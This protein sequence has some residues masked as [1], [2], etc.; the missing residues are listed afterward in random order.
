MEINF[1]SFDNYKNKIYSVTH[2]RLLCFEIFKFIFLYIIM[3]IFSKLSNYFPFSFFGEIN[4][5][6][7]IIIKIF[8]FSLLIDLSYY[9]LFKT[10][11]GIYSYFEIIIKLIIYP[12]IMKIF[13]LLL[14]FYSIYTINKNIELLM[15]KLNLNYINNIYNLESIN[16]ND[17]N[18]EEERNIE[19][20]AYLK[21]SLYVKFYK[22]YSFCASFFLLFYF[23]I[24]KQKFNLWP[25]LELGHI[26]N[27][28]KQI[29]S[30]I[31]NLKIII[32]PIYCIIYITLI[33]FYHTMKVIHLSFYYLTHFILNYILLFLST[34]S[35]INFICPKINYQSYETVTKGQVIRKQINLLKENSFYIIHHLKHLCDFY[36]FPH[37]IKLNTKL[38]SFEDLEIIKKKI[39]FYFDI[40]NKKY[41]LFLDKKKKVITSYIY[42][43]PFYN[44][45]IIIGKISNLIDF[46][47]NQIFENETNVQI[48]KLLIE[49]IGNLILFILDAKIIKSN[50]E[51]LLIYKEYIEILNE[52]LIELDKILSSVF[53]DKKLSEELN[54]DIYK[55]RKII[56]NYFCLIKI[57]QNKMNYII[58]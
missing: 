4:F 42:M 6:S 47:A 22:V 37:D 43:G 17:I 24:I 13:L 3:L 33:Y 35:I 46:S 52:K 38:L 36:I 49:L 18:D 14:S 12:N 23:I 58:E 57:K 56:N 48:I 50:E 45:K 5:V 21:N 40:L 44:L 15:P 26:D 8:F 41:S 16:L 1:F 51:K 54:S 2:L 19:I 25:K 32:I 31:N 27:F 10:N 39:F 11:E 9:Y 20:N 29:F 55:L 28:K 7:S 30:I 34:E 53:G